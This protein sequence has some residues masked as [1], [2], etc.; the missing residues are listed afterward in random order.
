MNLGVGSLTSQRFFYLHLALRALARQIWNLSYQNATSFIMARMRMRQLYFIFLVGLTATLALASSAAAQTG[1]RVVALERNADITILPNGDARFVETWVV[2][3]QNGPFTFAF[4]EIPK[5]KLRDIVA[6][7]VREGATVF[8]ED[9]GAF[10]FTVTETADAYKITWRFP[11][12]N[13]HA[14]FFS[15]TRAFELQYTVRGAARIY[16]DGD[17][18]WWKFIEADRAYPIKAARVTLHL[19]AEFAADQIKTSAYLNYAETVG[20]RVLDGRTIEFNGGPFAPDTF[21]EIRAQFPHVLDAAPEAWQQWDDRVERIAAQNNFIA[22]TAFAIIALGGPLALLTLWYLFG[23]DKPP[24]WR[25]EFL[26][27][28]P[29]DTP[30][31]VVGTLLDERADLQ[32]ILATI[33]NLAQRGYLRIHETDGFGAPE[34]ERTAKDDA[35]LASFERL[36]LDALLRGRVKRRLDGVR[37]SFYAYLGGLQ[38]DLYRQV[39]ERGFF[40]SSPLATRNLY[41]RIGKWGALALPLIGFATACFIF[42]LAPLAFLPLCG[43]EILFIALLGLSRVMPQRTAKGARAAAQWNAFKRYLA[44]LENYDSV[45]A[46]RDK[47]AEYLPY[48]IAFGLEKTWIEKFK[49]TDTPAPLWYIPYTPP[50]DD[51]TWRAA[52]NDAPFS[53]TSR[54]R[55]SFNPPK[56]KSDAPN[57][58]TF[59]RGAFV[60]LNRVSGNLFDFL[61]S[62]AAAFVEKPAAR[63]AAESLMRGVGDAV[64]WVSSSAA[65][66]SASD[67]SWSSSSSWSGGG[68]GGGGGGG[69]GSSGFG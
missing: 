47:F 14:N 38:D 50:P 34:F 5:N 24:T 56:E 30:P 28:P 60:G 35:A 25:A 4:R 8:Q 63:S 22:A 67:S 49:L 61:N 21:W 58:D 31:G 11:P 32:D 9:S 18:F 44:H 29:D 40:P 69:G 46:A 3:F 2:D 27:A 37:G 68:S 51:W 65:S 42:A 45:Q 23:R 6:W 66:G 26:S 17:Q 16:D 36:T 15:D 20:G 39:V 12:T 64:E 54:P 41:F 10:N 1:K 7:G 43:L 33:A 62:S 52:K 19:P 53:D 57:L 48:A 13:Q 59:A 55:A